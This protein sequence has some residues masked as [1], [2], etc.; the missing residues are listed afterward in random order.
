MHPVTIGYLWNDEALT[1]WAGITGGQ[2]VFRK[3][4]HSVVKGMV[5]L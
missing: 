5:I 2:L 3:H 4:G 1:R